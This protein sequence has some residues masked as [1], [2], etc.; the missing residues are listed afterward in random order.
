MAGK[1]V[2]ILFLI[3]F[4]AG[5]YF[6]YTKL[7]GKPLIPKM[8]MEDNLKPAAGEDSAASNIGSSFALVDQDG[9]KV[10]DQDFKGKKLLVFFGFTH[11]PD[12]CPVS[13]AVITEVMNELETENVSNVQPLFITVDP[14]RDTPAVLK[15]YLKDYHHSFEGLTGPKDETE[16]IEKGYKVF[17]EKT[18]DN[19]GHS[20]LIYYMDKNGQFISH[21]S[22]D[23]A[24]EDIVDYITSH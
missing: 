12:I 8:T 16:K 24:P 4:A 20:D 19:V 23:N 6:F 11:C 14:E 10:S 7:A 3:I 9:K 2:L 5:G 18:G 1:F 22:R 21:F 17:A 15:E 13:M